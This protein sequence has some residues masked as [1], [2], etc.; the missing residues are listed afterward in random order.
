MT[1][2]RHLLLIADLRHASPRWPALCGALILKGWDVSVVTA[3]LGKSSRERY[4]FPAVFAERARIV[5]AGPSEDSLQL[6]RR[7]FWRLGFRRGRSLTGQVIAELQGTAGR[8]A[9]ASVARHV[10]AL[11]GWPDVYFRWARPAADTALTLL[12]ERPCDAMVSSSPYPSAH[13]AAAHVKKRMPQVRWVADFRDLWVGNHNDAG[14]WWRRGVNRYWER[15]MAS[16]VSAFVVPSSGLADTL[17]SRY[18]QPIEVVPNGFIDYEPLPEILVSSAKRPFTLLYTGVRYERHQR[19][20]VLFEALGELKKRRL[21]EPSGFRAT[22][23]GPYDADL[24]L[25]AERFGVAELVEQVAPVSRSEARKAQLL[26]DALLYLQ[27]EDDGRADT[28]SPLKLQ[29]YVGSGRQILA[30]GGAANSPVTLL[31]R[32]TSRAG[33]CF[34]SAEVVN[35]LHDRIELWR[36]GEEISL[37]SGWAEHARQLSGISRGLPQLERLLSSS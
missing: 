12:A 10:E 18:K 27:W 33:V 8:S 21:I 32:Q 5:E 36:R 16:Q 7:V 11:M 35:W 28:V 22:F 20:D 25:A 30:T 19:I 6:F 26:A 31:L 37:P 9:V 2:T 17:R 23:V 4:G 1:R 14:V 3:P 29:E 13:V 15:Y 34:T 24:H